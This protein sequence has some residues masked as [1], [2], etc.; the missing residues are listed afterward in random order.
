MDTAAQVA[1]LKADGQ[2]SYAASQFPNWRN[3]KG[4]GLTLGIMYK[5]MEKE[6]EN[7]LP[8]TKRSA[9]MTPKYLYRIGASLIDS[10]LLGHRIRGASV[11][12]VEAGGPC[13]Q[14]GLVG[15]P[16]SEGGGDIIVKVG[17]RKIRRVNDVLVALGEYRPGQRVKIEFVRGRKLYET[18][19]TLAEP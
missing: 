1:V 8:H 15:A 10:G 5:K 4:I 19:V 12:E 18:E 13:A 11:M 17:D 6:V 2:Y 9:C 16:E 7:Y 14:A 3:G